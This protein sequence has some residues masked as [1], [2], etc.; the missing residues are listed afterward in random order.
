MNNIDLHEILWK[1]RIESLNPMQEETIQ[2]YRKGDD[3]VLLSPTGSGKTLAYL[4]PLVQHL[5]SARG[6]VQA[7]VLVP[8]REL[9]LQTEQVFKS[10]GTAYKVVSC[11]GGR[12]AMDEHR[13]LRSVQPQVVVATPGRM[14]DHLSKGNIPV[15][16]ISTLVI[17]EFDKC[18]ELGFQEE[19][20]Q[21][22]SKLPKLKRRFLLSATDA[23]QIPNFVSPNHFVKLNYLSEDEQTVDRVSLYQVFSPV[24]D[25]LETLERLIRKSG[26][27]SSLVF[28][29]Y[30]ESAEQ[31]TRYL[32]KEH[33]PCGMFHGGMEQDLR[34]RSLCKFRN[35]SCPV[36]ISTD[37]AA[38]GLDIADVQ[39]I[40]H[41]HLPVSEEVFVHRNGRTARWQSGGEVYIML[42]SDEEL[43][44]YIKND[45]PVFDLP[46]R[47]LE[48][49]KL[50]WTTL[51]INKGRRD[52]V[53]RVDIVGFLYKK[54][55]LGREDI[56]IIDV[57]ERYSFVAIRQERV[58]PLL[59]LIGGE[60]LKNMRVI[61]EEAR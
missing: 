6:G 24:K 15:E 38:R 52:K 44:V 30:R 10:M 35:G 28:V 48:L 12:P 1:L 61:I 18:L 22:I 29:N 7:V 21:V 17:D 19:M 45:I 33:F 26:A 2:A 4:I 49:P 41:F 56:G 51:Y 20:S 36:L 50:Q 53:N 47:V 13:T 57:K 34:E 42:G 39:H 25:K 8:S 37:L 55:L 54:G 3:L 40:V 5:D 31:I 60:K 27:T 16:N 11:Y 46:V 23:P 58:K 32:Q 59:A 14:N 43:P 9:A